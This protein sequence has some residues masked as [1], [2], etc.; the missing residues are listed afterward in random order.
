MCR[1][2]V[3]DVLL[4]HTVSTQHFAMIAC[5]DNQGIPGQP[6]LVQSP[7]NFAHPVIN[8]FYKAVIL[9]DHVLDLFSI[10][11]FRQVFS[12]ISSCIGTVRHVIIDT[13]RRLHVLR[14]IHVIIGFGRKHWSVRKME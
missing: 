9:G 3:E 11:V 4:T 5:E 7:Q 13:Y 2:F 10:P 12:S 8:L 14:R 1:L 6:V